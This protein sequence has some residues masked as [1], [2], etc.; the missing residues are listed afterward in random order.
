MSRTTVADRLRAFA[1]DPFAL[2]AAF[3]FGLTVLALVGTQIPPESGE[4]APPSL[5]GL[6]LILLQTVPV[7]FR[8]R[9]PVRVL[10]LIGLATIGHAILGERA[11]SA[12]FGV[13]FALYTVA[14]E[15]DEEEA[16]V[17][18]GITLGGIVLSFSFYLFDLGLGTIVV[19]EQLVQNLL[20]FVIAWYLGR[21]M[22]SRREGAEQLELR[23]RQL[24]VEREENA[25]LAV[26]DERAR[27]A[28]ELHDV[29]AHHVSVMAVQASAARRSLE[30]RGLLGPADRDD[31]ARGALDAVETT[32]R[33]TLTEMRRMVGLLRTDAADERA[34]QPGLARLDGLIAQVREAGLPVEVEVDGEVRE[35]P[36]GVDLAAYRIVQEALTNTLKHAGR[37]RATVR[38]RYA[39]D[40]LGVEV[41]DDGRGAAAGLLGDADATRHGHGIAGMRERVGLVGGSLEAGPR[42][43]G[44][45]VVVARLP[46]E[47]GAAS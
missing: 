4:F 37:A 21:I 47:A 40:E 28:R 7:A 18:L 44:G 36:T 45:Y 3:A 5:L 20:I 31:P 26:S 34:P 17:S 32:A 11:T 6:V 1:A 19:V 46:V 23:N 22:R 29:V 35:L 42:M 25:R 9:S 12:T 41:E 39:A 14:A 15:C 16:R 10:A 24:V 43:S 13:L 27:I 38:L 33:T 2:D 8:R 30:A